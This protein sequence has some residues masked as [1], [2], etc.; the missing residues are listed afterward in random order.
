MRKLY[1]GI[2]LIAL[3]GGPALGADMAV[4]GP[5]YQPSMMPAAFS[6][7]GFYF[8][9]HVGGSWA[10]VDWTHTNTGGIVETFG[11]EGS[12][13]A[14]GGHAGAMYQ[15]S[16]IVVGIEGTYTRHNLSQTNSA[17]LS[18]DRSNAFDLK[19]V[20]TVVGRLGTAWDRWLVYAQGGWAA[21]ETDFRRF[22]TSTNSTTASSSGW[23][24]GWTVGVGG[25]YAI[26]SNIIF[27]A[28]Y[29]FVRLD[30]DNRTQTLA[31]GFVGTDTVTDATAN[32]HQATARL[33][34]KFP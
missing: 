28:E 32:V 1:V 29:N 22:V 9:G 25:A 18:A 31:A 30:I 21:G 12:G 16:N 17:L 7:T 3:A 10:N 19:N 27:G 13:I 34:F 8:G 4:K 11:Q 24:N 2:A 33:S 23:D 15:F 6:W 26:T 14:Y 5:V 20:V